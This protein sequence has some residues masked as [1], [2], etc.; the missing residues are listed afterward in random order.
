M[1][2]SM[3]RPQ[4]HP[5]SG[6][7]WLRKRVPA[8][9]VALI[10][11]REITLSL[12]TKDPVEART[13]YVQELAKLEQRWAGLRAGPRS[14]SEVEAHA[15]AVPVYEDW[16]ARHRANPS[17]QAFW[18]VDLAPR[19]WVPPP[20]MSAQALLDELRNPTIDSDGRRVR[21]MEAWCE[22]QASGLLEQH[23]FGTDEIGR[24]RMARA[25]AAA[26]QRASQILRSF[27]SGEYG[28]VLAEPAK[29]LPVTAHSPVPAAAKAV[30]FNDL[31]QGWQAE[32]KPRAKTVYEWTREIGK[33]GTFLGHTDAA[34]ITVDD[35]VRWKESLIAEG[36][37]AKT[38]GDSK[39]AALRTV[40]QWGVDSR[41][42]PS[43]PAAGVRMAA[44]KGG[45][46]RR[47]YTDAEA[48]TILS[49]ALRE[50][51]PVL[52]WVPWLCAYS[53]ARLSE[54]C[55]LRVA[56]VRLV[57]GVWCM[58]IDGEAGSVKTA[59]SERIV[60]LHQAVLDAGF[61]KFVHVVG[62]GPLFAQL[63]PDKFGQ[64]GGNGTKV[65]GPWVRELGL[66]EKRLAPVH[67][68]RH[69]MSSLARRYRLAEDVTRALMG[70]SKR[71]VAEGYGE[72]EPAVLHHELMKIPALALPATAN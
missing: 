17:E 58:V 60:P 27:A 24:R 14:L 22:E 34:R 66:D 52:R 43:N 29:G 46:G 33:F 19:L 9:L 4:L 47:S 5:R 30:A 21:E 15:L 23:G 71:D 3:A 41:R 12:Q 65:L 56:D 35:V 20:P 28:A 53:G 16:L 44:K 11:R 37:S 18:R 8:D 70:H 1:V 25:V 69:R 7:Y 63:P 55:Q 48:A 40:L 38:I 67:S 13:R 68:W 39:L 54:V 36:L 42:L 51:N 2:L 61:L 64:R 45:K 62:T 49:A 72:F 57:E 31:L 50:T 59:S 26:V 6:V 32:T 10:G